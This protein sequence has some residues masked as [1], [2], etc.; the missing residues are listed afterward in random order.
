VKPNAFAL[1]LIGKDGNVALR[2][3]AVTPAD[4]LASTIDAMPMRQEE[5]KR[6]EAN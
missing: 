4:T 5:L 1:V 3:N 2:R 6:G